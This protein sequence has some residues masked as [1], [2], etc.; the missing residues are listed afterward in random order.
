MTTK[1]RKRNVVPP[2][3]NSARLSELPLPVM[4]LVPDEPNSENPENEM[5]DPLGESVVTN[6]S[7]DAFDRTTNV[8]NDTVD[9]I[10]FSY[11]LNEETGS[12]LLAIN[13]ASASTDFSNDTV[14][15][16]NTDGSSHTN[17]TGAESLLAQNE[18]SA[19][20]NLASVDV[21]QSNI[22]VLSATLNS[23]LN[24]ETPIKEEPQFLLM[25]DEDAGAID[26]IFNVSYEK[27]NESDDDILIHCSDAIPAPIKPKMVPY[28]TKANDVIS[29]NI[30]FAINV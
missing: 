22:S 30:P 15:D 26:T 18:P 6:E 13:E 20:N 10:D 14:N 4:V 8:F 24:I 29:G 5:V 9:A 3:Y 21:N 19:S 25:S 1:R 11:Q 7:E 17:A 12:T 28:Q 27:V 2:V 23:A 16:N